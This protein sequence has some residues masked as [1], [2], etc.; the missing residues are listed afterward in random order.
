[1]GHTRKSGATVFHLGMLMA[2][3]ILAHIYSSLKLKH[4]SGVMKR[5][6]RF[7]AAN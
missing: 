4:T 3:D 1:M 2:G 7:C 6:Y 5:P